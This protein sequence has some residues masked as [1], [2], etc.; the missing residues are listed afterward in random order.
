MH[1][2]RRGFL[3]TALAATASLSLARAVTSRE[4]GSDSG[5]EQT[6]ERAIVL[7]TLMSSNPQFDVQAALRAGMTGG[8]VDILAPWTEPHAFE[9][10]AQW[11]AAFADPRSPFLNVRKAADFAAAKS[12]GRFAVVLNC[13]NASILGTPMPANSDENSVAL[14]KFYAAGLRVLQLTYTTSNGLGSG[15]SEHIDAGLLRLGEL[16]VAQMNEL[17]MLVD[18]SHCSEST[19]LQAIALSSKPCAVTHAGCLALYDDKRNK[20]DKVIRALAAKGGYMGIYNMTLWMTTRSTSSV[21]DIVDH[22]DHVV[23]IGGIDLVGFGADHAPLGDTRSQSEKVA[24]MQS[25]VDINAKGGFPGNEPMHGHVTASDL[26]GPERL[27]VLA[28]ALARRG[29]KSSQI[30]KVLGANFVRVFGSVCG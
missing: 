11:N 8:V 17:G 28:R 1:I 19:T 25:F 26:D 14:R 18:L 15:Y 6:Y 24:S 10:I 23:Q 12:S 21:E 13:Q 9:M 22:I 20:S 7:D 16:V 5:V 29:Y 27:H 4:P 2:D 30:E 3:S